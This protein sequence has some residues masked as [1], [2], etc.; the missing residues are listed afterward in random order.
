VAV[1]VTVTLSALGAVKG[2]KLA[3]VIP[4]DRFSVLLAGAV[5]AALA[6]SIAPARRAIRL[7]IA[8]NLAR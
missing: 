4:G 7:P 6:A 5:V 8:E 3:L 1:S 2:S